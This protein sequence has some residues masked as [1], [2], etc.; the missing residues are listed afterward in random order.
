MRP[1]C[2]HAAA[3]CWGQ[4]CCCL[5]APVHGSLLL[6][7]WFEN[8]RKKMHGC[9]GWKLHDRMKD[10]VA[11]VTRHGQLQQR[12]RKQAI[13]QSGKFEFECHAMWC[14]GA[15]LPL[16]LKTGDSLQLMPAENACAQLIWP[17]LRR[18]NTHA[19]RVPTNCCTPSPQV[20]NSCCSSP[21][22]RH[23][24]QIPPKLLPPP[25]PQSAKVA[26]PPEVAS[27]SKCC[28]TSQLPTSCRTSPHA[29]ARP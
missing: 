22:R 2:C 27:T 10:A 24:P 26:A 5:V 3:A 13:A 6:L 21:S 23:L 8:L 29:T 14:T 18:Y 4:S 1:A 28:C 7:C 11:A 16:R 19:Q 25:T 20:A 17:I 15:R 9:V 12:V